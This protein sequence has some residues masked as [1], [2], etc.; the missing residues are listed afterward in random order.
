MA[1]QCHSWNQ[2]TFQKSTDKIP[3][4]IIPT[5]DKLYDEFRS[6]GAAL[7]AKI[8][9]LQTTVSNQSE[10]DG[11]ELTSMSNLRECVR[12]A[13][14]VVSTASST[15]TVEASDR[16][17]VKHGSDFGDVFVKDANE[18]M[19]RWMSS[20]TVYE[21]DDME[22]LPDPSEASTGDVPTEYMSDSDSDIESE[23]IRALFNNAKKL[24]EDGDFT[25]A[26]RKLRN[27]LTRFSTNASSVL[28]T[29]PQSASVSGVSKA[30]LLELLTDTYCLLGSWKKAKATLMEKL[31]VIERQVGKKDELY[32]WDTM[33][34]AEL[35]MKNKEYVEAHLHCRR[36]LRGFKKLGE[37]GFKGYEKC[38]T[39][40]IELC[41]DEGKVDEEEAYAALLGSHQAKA[42][43]RSLS[44]S[45][46]EALATTKGVVHTNESSISTSQNDRSNIHTPDMI[47]NEGQ[48]A[49][50][51]EQQ[52]IDGVHGENTEKKDNIRAGGMPTPEPQPLSPSR[53]GLVP[54]PPI[55]SPVAIMAARRAREEQKQKEQRVEVRT[56]NSPYPMTSPG[57][58][59][60]SSD[61]TISTKDTSTSGETP[62]TELSASIYEDKVK[63][64]L[65]RYQVLS[66]REQ[67]PR[68]ASE[69]S[70]PFKQPALQV[71][72]SIQPNT[73]PL[74]PP[75]YNAVDLDAL[76]R[77]YT[78]KLAVSTFR[79]QLFQSGPVDMA[80]KDVARKSHSRSL[81][82]LLTKYCERFQG[83]V[84][85]FSAQWELNGWSCMVKINA[86]Q[87]CKVS[88]EKTEQLARDAATAEACRLFISPA[89]EELLSNNEK[90]RDPFSDKEVFVPEIDKQWKEVSDRGETPFGT[91]SP[92]TPRIMISYDKNAYENP[93]GRV[94]LPAQEL[95]VRRTA[96]DSQLSRN[97]ALDVD[98]P[99]NAP[100]VSSTDT[101]TSATKHRR[102]ITITGGQLSPPFQDTEWTPGDEEGLNQPHGQQIV[103]TGSNS[104]R[105][106]SP[107]VKYADGAAE[108]RTWLSTDDMTC[109][110]CGKD[111]SQLSGGESWIHTSTCTGDGSFQNWLVK[112][113]NVSVK[114]IGR[115]I[116]EDE[117]GD[118]SRG[119][120]NGQVRD[121]LFWSDHHEVSTTD[122][123]CPI[124]NED[125]RELSENSISTHVNSCID[126]NPV[127]I[128]TL[129]TADQRENDIVPPTPR[130]PTPLPLT[131]SISQDPPAPLSGLWACDKCKSE[132]MQYLTENTCASCGRQCDRQCPQTGNDFI[133]KPFDQYRTLLTSLDLDA[134]VT[135][136]G[137]VLRR[138]V[139]LLGDTLCGKTWL[140][141]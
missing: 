48:R 14:D 141:R 105:S 70:E 92:E 22:P 93:I 102:A 130:L 118:P 133:R 63:S 132:C 104:W 45:R 6:L 17:S 125:M 89:L 97:N 19:L 111:L 127:P 110:T 57:T 59:D 116:N 28:L 2:V 128:A 72:S 67:T 83:R 15:L 139:L 54:S 11:H 7:N 10:Q 103:S 47:M 73:G 78:S 112:P 18:T 74:W 136:D 43:R 41:H 60:I 94:E 107:P 101:S 134:L 55:K 96:S 115:W 3:E 137:R 100:Q 138:K 53:R 12:S 29:P 42:K 117:V 99:K 69:T 75:G 25:G 23:M 5:L 123:L 71:T 77:E 120:R 64:V 109:E 108:A 50:S 39:F 88:G 34:L 66:S 56:P 76:E 51:G 21:F 13:A 40:L 9:N 36:S 131:H 106:N 81:L 33:K 38:L 135:P 44:N 26:E 129:R 121:A 58:S 79:G 46:P 37:P 85:Y 20:N 80:T 27:C 86:T 84:P 1:D 32:L 98:L 114:S 65:S 30:E 119:R 87:G 90:L 140:A 113:E 68:S 122:M 91:L 95:S 49:N 31:S 35:M 4:K 8:E 124:C 82:D 62:T 24:K 16:V 52:N 126:G 61:H